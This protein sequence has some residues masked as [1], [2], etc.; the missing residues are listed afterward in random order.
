MSFARAPVARAPLVR[1]L[2]EAGCEQPG[3]A[4]D[5]LRTGLRDTEGRHRIDPETVK[6]E[7]VAAGFKLD[8]ESKIL[9]N[10]VDDH[11]KFVFDPA[12]RGKTD[13]FPLRFRK[14]K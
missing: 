10:L 5:D 8:A 14:P 2:C 1:G 11:T 4:P 7:V 9:A 6:G 3:G 12:V 13:Q